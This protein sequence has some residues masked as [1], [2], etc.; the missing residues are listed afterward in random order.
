MRRTIA[1]SSSVMVWTTLALGHFLAQSAL[2]QGFDRPND[3]ARYQGFKSPT[4]LELAGSE[5]EASVDYS[6][7]GK[8]VRVHLSWTLPDGRK[9][10]NTQREATAFWP[11]EVRSHAPNELIV[12][13]VTT[14]GETEIQL[15][16]FGQPRV[17]PPI[18]PVGGGDP[19]M[20]DAYVPVASKT[21]LFNDKDPARRFVAH[22]LPNRGD[23]RSVFV[24][25]HE[26][27][28]LWSF[29]L[30]SVG[31]A[32]V[33]AATPN[34][35]GVPVAA[36]LVNDYK[37]ALSGDHVNDGYLYWIFSEPN[38]GPS[39]IV[40]FHDTDR[41][42]TLDSSEQLDGPLWSARTYGDH[43]SWIELGG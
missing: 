26:Q 9:H 25:F 32:R 41:D 36:G 7:A 11:T 18:Y 31:M 1:R 4:S 43:A 38:D 16:T 5:V 17:L 20:P 10:S 8:Q 27:K 35:D 6:F 21:T 19:I 39:G 42:G 28:D 15:W 13:G 29:N 12:A 2:A 14:R 3:P 24:Q 23:P 33:F 30:S 34:T 22:I 37:V 40:I